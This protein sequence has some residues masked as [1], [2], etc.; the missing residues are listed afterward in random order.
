[1]VQILSSF[2]DALGGFI[3]I[4]FDVVSAVQLH[5]RATQ[6]LLKA[7]VERS[8]QEKRD[9]GGKH[10]NKDATSIGNSSIGTSLTTVE[11]QRS[12]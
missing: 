5:V 10:C 3:Q 12:S 7:D 8:S 2:R 11:V 1:L 4:L 9:T 6:I